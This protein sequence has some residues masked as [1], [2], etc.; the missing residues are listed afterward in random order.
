MIRPTTT[1]AYQELADGVGGVLLHLETGQYHG[2]NSVGALVWSLVGD[3]TSFGDL[4][5]AVREQVEDAPED[6]ADDVAAFLSE[7][8]ARDLIAFEEGGSDG[9]G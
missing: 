5:D 4:V 6:L 9:D 7:L 2:V 1:L 3:G 8:H